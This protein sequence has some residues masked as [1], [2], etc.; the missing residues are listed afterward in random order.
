M[1]E[2]LSTQT[3]SDGAAVSDNI[4][5]TSHTSDLVGNSVSLTS[6]NRDYVRFDQEPLEPQNSDVE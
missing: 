1:N 2:P 4:S 6:Q 3:L 5:V